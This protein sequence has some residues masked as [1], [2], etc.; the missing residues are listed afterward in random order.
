M[1]LDVCLHLL[2]RVEQLALL[3]GF[4]AMEDGAS[5]G[6]SFL[7]LFLDRLRF[8]FDGLAKKDERCLVRY[9]LISNSKTP[10]K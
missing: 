3:H 2:K 10:A 8:L 9:F 7:Q 4:V 6:L 1:L 5:S